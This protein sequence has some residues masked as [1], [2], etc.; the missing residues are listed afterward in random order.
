VVELDLLLLKSYDKTLLVMCVV[1][2]TCDEV[3]LET[4][5]CVDF[6]RNNLQVPV[7]KERD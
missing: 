1:R 3:E 2:C 5:N 4:R 7:S 6:S